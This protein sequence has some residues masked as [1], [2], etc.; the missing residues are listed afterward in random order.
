[1]NAPYVDNGKQA[2]RCIVHNLFIDVVKDRLV[3]RFVGNDRLLVAVDLLVVRG[4]KYSKRSR[5]MPIIVL[6]MWKT[7]MCVLC[8]H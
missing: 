3:L 4:S 5:H 6:N 7:M 2:T 8:I 1:M